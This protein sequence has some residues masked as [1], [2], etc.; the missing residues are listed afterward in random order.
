MIEKVSIILI[1][2]T[3]LLI[4]RGFAAQSSQD[5]TASP[6]LKD[7]I[8]EKILGG[9]DA[10]IATQDEYIIGHGDVLSVTI[11]EEGDIVSS[12]LPIFSY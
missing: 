1:L 11:F 4:P 12:G 6:E 2:T 9:R 7:S 3:F 10:L 5:V 8:R